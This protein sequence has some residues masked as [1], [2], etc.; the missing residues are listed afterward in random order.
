VVYARWP[1]VH[2]NLDAKADRAVTPL[3]RLLLRVNALPD[4]VELLKRVLVHRGRWEN[5]M[6][7]YSPVGD[8]R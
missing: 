3:T 4:R 6:T 7:M 1:D 5:G 8:G 2:V